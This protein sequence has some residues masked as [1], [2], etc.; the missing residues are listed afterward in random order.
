DQDL[1]M[2]VKGLHFNGKIA[3]DNTF[4]EGER[5]IND[6]YNNARSKYINPQDG[7]VNLDPLYDPN[8]PFSFREGK[9]WSTSEGSV[10]DG[11]T[12]RNVY[13]QLQLNYDF[14]LGGKHNFSE[15]GL[16]NRTQNA[17]GSIIPHARENWVFR[18]TYNYD[19]KYIVEYNGSYNGSEKFGEGYRF[20]FFSSGGLGWNIHN[21]S[22]MS[23]V[24]LL[25]NLKVRA[26]Y[27]TI[28]DD[29]TNSRW[30]YRTQW[31]YG[32]QTHLGTTGE[33]ASASPYTW[34][35]EASLGNPDVHWATV[36]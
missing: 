20:G 14:T 25:N 30:L 5:G 28:G 24:E 21:E 6:L 12:Y 18:S 34:Y 10:Q 19:Q 7:S 11:Q 27:G 16:V 13:Y 15:M 1:H 35:R 17:T 9:V 23:N 8:T 22:F 4:I 31:D 32:T 3:I 26:S 33:D 2:L 36:T 29:N